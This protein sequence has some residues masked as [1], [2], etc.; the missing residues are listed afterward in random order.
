MSRIDAEVLKSIIQNTFTDYLIENL[1]IEY[2]K[3]KEL[4]KDFTKECLISLLEILGD[5][6]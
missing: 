3:A 6:R 5:D 1:N 2:D 4:A